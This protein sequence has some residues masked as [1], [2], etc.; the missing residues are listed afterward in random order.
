MS[1]TNC[2]QTL[3][4][5]KRMRSGSNIAAAMMVVAQ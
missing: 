2:A 3:K 4:E 5:P 1:G